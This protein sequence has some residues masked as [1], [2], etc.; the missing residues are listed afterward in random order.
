MTG[1]H[2]VESLTMFAINTGSLYA[3]HKR[4]GALLLMTLEP[5]I[6]HVKSRVIPLYALE[7]GAYKPDLD[8]LARPVAEELRGYYNRHAIELAVEL[9]ERGVDSVSLAQRLAPQSPST[10]T[11]A[12][13]EASS[14]KLVEFAFDIK[15]RAVARV[16]AMSEA[17]AREQVT[18][19][20]TDEAWI[21][22]EHETGV[23]ITAASLDDNGLGSCFEID[24]ED[25]ETEN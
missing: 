9:Q 12:S 6:Q 11:A 20:L 4:L 15:L 13:P 24:G 22:Y 10:V 18:A 8:K 17:E 5:W 25:V 2:D 21:D 3:E 19:A 7:L 14:P 1:R 16:R 23:R